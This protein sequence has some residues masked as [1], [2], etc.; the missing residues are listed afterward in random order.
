MNGFNSRLLILGATALAVVVA[1]S[2][3]YPL[4]LM[5]I[6]CLGLFAAGTNLLVG[7]LGMVS[8]GQAAFYGMGAYLS[9]WL[10]RTYGFTPELAILAA[11]IAGAIL[12]VLLGW[13]SIRRRGL[14]FSMITLAFCQMVYF[15]CLRAP[16]THGED[17]IQGIPR[18]SFLGL[19]SLNSDGAMYVFVG[20]AFV[21]ILALILRIVHSPFGH[22]VQGIHGN[23]A[24]M[25]SLGYNA[26]RYRLGVFV[27]AAAIAGAA[28]GMKSLIFGI[29]TLQDVG[30]VLAGE[31]VL[32]ILVGGM[33]TL[34]GPL[35][36][37]VIVASLH[38]YL[39]GF[40][41]W[42][43]VAQGLVFVVCVMTLR[44][45]LVGEIVHRMREREPRDTLAERHGI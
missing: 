37:A 33:G 9:G 8:F 30:F 45:G 26:D 14:Y 2:F 35:V 29:A 24:R 11:T 7:Y 23:E 18:G 44:K 4:F 3:A 39:A 40:G 5:N 12:G 22:V 21:L 31:V 19:F 16:F 42:V 17:G 38:Y 1:P 43:L 28:G 6:M 15:I 20:V 32:M 25:I 27:L 34:I 13:L 36:G 41:S 10:A